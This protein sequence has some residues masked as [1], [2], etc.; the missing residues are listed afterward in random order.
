M[1]RRFLGQDVPA[2]GFSLGFERLVDLVTLPDSAESDAV[3]L[4]YDKDVDPVRL[5]A[6]KTEALGS[7][8]RVR[9]EKRTKNTKNL[10]AGLAAQGFGAF[11][12]VTADTA[13]LDGV[14]FRPLT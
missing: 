3:V 7:H 13:S 12:T 8:R 6:L 1:I 9:L 14:E 4:V 5:A 10:L 2:G 11:A